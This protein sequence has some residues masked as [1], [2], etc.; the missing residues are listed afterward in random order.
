[1]SI[2]VVS[3]MLA[4]PAHNEH[5]EKARIAQ[6]LS[7]DN[8]DVLLYIQDYMY[9][10]QNQATFIGNLAEAKKDGGMSPSNSEATT[11]VAPY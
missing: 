8:V 7:K 2:P 1:M 10:D 11:N 5:S 6:N 4:I 9:R 3:D